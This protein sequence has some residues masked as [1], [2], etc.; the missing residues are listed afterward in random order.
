MAMMQIPSPESFGP[1]MTEEVLQRLQGA[2]GPQGEPGAQGPSGAMDPNASVDTLS[3]RSVKPGLGTAVVV[4]TATGEVRALTSS[5][6]FKENIR[7]ASD[8]VSHDILWELN[9]VAYNYKGQDPVEDVSFGFIA[10]DVADVCQSL[11]IYQDG[12]PYSLQYSEFIPLIVAGMQAHQTELLDAQ[13]KLANALACSTSA[14][15]HLDEVERVGR[16]TSDE[17]GMFASII[18]E[19]GQDLSSLDERQREVDQASGLLREK[20]KLAVETEREHA[21]ALGRSL[22]A[23]RDELDSLKN[24]LTKQRNQLWIACA[25][26]LFLMGIST[27][28][29][30]AM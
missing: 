29:G 23:A 7:P 22:E 18:K 10:E 14:Q 4:D 25:V 20:I 15:A 5:E 6:K 24:N 28:L 11:V 21:N 12:S 30:V 17:V 19:F 8:V 1:E 26:F 13:S 27:W 2:A 9:P 16:K 3:I